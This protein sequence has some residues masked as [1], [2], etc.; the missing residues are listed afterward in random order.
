MGDT[1]EEAAIR[2]L[3]HQADDAAAGMTEAA[4]RAKK[5]Q[6]EF[7]GGHAPN[8]AGDFV[9]ATSDWMAGKKCYD[10]AKA[11]IDGIRS[12]PGHYRG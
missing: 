1:S 2:E 10:L 8:A 11:A 12:R 3:Q 7:A 6:V 5:A 4:A 9:K